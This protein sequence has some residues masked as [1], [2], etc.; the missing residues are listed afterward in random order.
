MNTLIIIGAKYLYLL[1]VI[2]AIAPFFLSDKKK[3]VVIF[4]ILDLTVVYMVGLFGGILYYDPRP[5]VSEHITPL[6]SHV[7][8]NGFPSDH[9]LLAAALASILYCYNRRLGLVV[10][11]IA[12]LVGVSR[13]LAG[14]HHL[15][16]VVGSLGIAVVVTFIVYV[17][18][19]KRFFA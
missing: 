11:V 18:T 17:T 19:R 12:I 1:A 13:M 7:A 9:T 5:F 10:F 14:I 4:S 3:E 16:D 6:I 8:D 2:I 15:I